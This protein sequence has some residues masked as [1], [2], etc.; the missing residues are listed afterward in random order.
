MIIDTMFDAIN[1]QRTH[2]TVSYIQR[3]RHIGYN[4]AST[5]LETMKDAGIVEPDGNDAKIVIKSLGEIKLPK[6]VKV[7]IPK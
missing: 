4:R 1:A 6:G 7:K 2:I 5:L 3:N